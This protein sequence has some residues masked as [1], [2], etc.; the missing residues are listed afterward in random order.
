M[1]EEKRPWG[2]LCLKESMKSGHRHC[3][4]RGWEP[5]PTKVWVGDVLL[6]CSDGQ[7]QKGRQRGVLAS[8]VFCCSLPKKLWPKQG[9][10]AGQQLQWWDTAL[11]WLEGWGP[12]WRGKSQLGGGGSTWGQ[13]S[14]GDIENPAV[15]KV[16]TVREQ[17]AVLRLASCAHMVERP[18]KGPSS[19]SSSYNP[20]PSVSSILRFQ[21]HMSSRSFPCST[22][23]PYKLHTTHGWRKCLLHSSGEPSTS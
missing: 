19:H 7:S 11:K 6:G 2:A 4:W 15:V 8:E 22:P 3:C 20:A 10:Q 13:N 9:E 17:I 14:P 12:R 21:L 23:A 1:L 18:E 16:A 5:K